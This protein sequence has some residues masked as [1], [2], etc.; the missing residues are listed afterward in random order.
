[1]KLRCAGVT[2]ITQVIVTSYYI[3]NNNF[4]FFKIYRQVKSLN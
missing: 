2:K 3:A 4:T 1:M